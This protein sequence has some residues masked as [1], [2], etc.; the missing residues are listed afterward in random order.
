M[1]YMKTVKQANQKLDLELETYNR[2]WRF[3][4]K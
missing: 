3:I 2:N 4:N 1:N